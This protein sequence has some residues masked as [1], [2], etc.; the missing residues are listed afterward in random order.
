MKTLTL[1]LTLLLLAGV[2]YAEDYTFKALQIS[3]VGLSWA[4]LAITKIGLK[5]GAIEV[6]PFVRWYIE[7]PTLTIAVNLSANLLI[8]WGTSKLYKKNK[9]LGV[10]AIITVNLVRGY[11]L[12]LNIKELKKQ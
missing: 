2:L 9:T 7:K 3:Q 4:D 10:L 6:N 5:R 12:Y 8:T 1:L 11:V